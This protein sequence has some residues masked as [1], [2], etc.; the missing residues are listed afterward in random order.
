MKHQNSKRSS[1][2]LKGPSI[3]MGIINRKIYW[4]LMPG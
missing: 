2:Y 4:T 3:A 1:N